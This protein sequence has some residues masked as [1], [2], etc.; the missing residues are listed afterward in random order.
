[1]TAAIGLGM[2]DLF[3]KPPEGILH[4]PAGRRRRAAPPIPAKDALSILNE[5]ALVVCFVALRLE[6]D[7][8]IE[9]HRG[10]LHRA[11]KRINTV[12]ES[13]IAAP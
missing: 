1:M 4:T 6:Q 9:A 12:R 11:A 10:H 5:E 3:N 8:P 2:H 7:E 13:W